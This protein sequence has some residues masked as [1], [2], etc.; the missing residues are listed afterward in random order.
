MASLFARLTAWRRPAV[1]QEKIR[2]PEPSHLFWSATR[3][4]RFARIV[5]GNPRRRGTYDENIRLL[6]A[7]YS[8]KVGG[9]AHVRLF[10]QKVN[11]ILFAYAMGWD[12]RATLKLFDRSAWN[13]LLTM[14]IRSKCEHCRAIGLYCHNVVTLY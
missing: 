8:K 7:V 1:V 13:T 3:A 12:M 5:S 2:A 14:V 9:E 6:N 11:P 10:M 4:R